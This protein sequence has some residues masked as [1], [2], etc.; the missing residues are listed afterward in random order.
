MSCKRLNW[1]YPNNSQGKPEN[2]KERK[3]SSATHNN[4][5]ITRHW[6]GFFPTLDKPAVND[7]R[8]S[9]RTAANRNKTEILKYAGKYP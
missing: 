3:Y 4:G 1:E 8:K 5:I 2:R 7:A 6:T 9:A